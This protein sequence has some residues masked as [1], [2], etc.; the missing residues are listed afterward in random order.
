MAYT[1][2][3]VVSMLDDEEYV[4]HDVD[5]SGDNLGMDIEDIE[6]PYNIGDLQGN[7]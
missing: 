7:N 2:A 6:N 5:S 3:E 4:F 1:A